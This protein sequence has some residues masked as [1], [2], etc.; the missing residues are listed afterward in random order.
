MTAEFVILW[1]TTRRSN[2]CATGS[3]SDCQPLTGSETYAGEFD[4]ALRLDNFPSRCIALEL[5]ALLALCGNLMNF[6]LRVAIVRL[7]REYQKQGNFGHSKRDPVSSFLQVPVNGRSWLLVSTS[8]RIRLSPGHK[9]H[10]TCAQQSRSE[11]GHISDI[12]M[13]FM[14]IFESHQMSDSDHLSAYF[15]RCIARLYRLR[16]NQNLGFLIE[17]RFAIGSR[18]ESATREREPRIPGFRVCQL[19]VQQY[20]FLSHFSRVT[21]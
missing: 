16:Y 20:S 13:I 5:D 9:T 6:K 15:F 3:K 21:D 10:R 1:K 7:P 19:P 12:L 2:S 8:V 11:C 4:A 17:T 18:S 14:T